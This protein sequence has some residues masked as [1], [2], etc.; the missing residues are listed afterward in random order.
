[1]KE[2]LRFGLFDWVE[3]SDTRAPGEVRL[4]PMGREVG[5]PELDAR[6]AEAGPAER[7]FDDERR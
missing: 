5:Y 7:G 4:A 3:A 2:T 6:V 1:M